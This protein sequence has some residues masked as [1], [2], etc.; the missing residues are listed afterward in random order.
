M[1]TQVILVVDYINIETLPTTQSSTIKIETRLYEQVRPL[2]TTQLPHHHAYLAA[3]VVLRSAPQYLLA[4]LTSGRDT[5]PICLS[6][7]T[8]LSKTAWTRDR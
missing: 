1:D 8:A 7:S 6:R 2:D 4:P 3:H 5:K